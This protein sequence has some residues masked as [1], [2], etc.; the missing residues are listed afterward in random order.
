MNV[1]GIDSDMMFTVVLTSTESKARFH[2]IEI[3]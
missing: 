2:F 3:K 1:W